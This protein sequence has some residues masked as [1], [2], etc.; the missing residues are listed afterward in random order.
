MLWDMDK[1]GCLFMQPESSHKASINII[2][3]EECQSATEN[4][5]VFVK[6]TRTVT[7]IQDQE[8]ISAGI[9]GAK[10]FAL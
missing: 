8:E 3:D 2:L 6:N 1:V 7:Q 10:A 5:S 4:Q 9:K